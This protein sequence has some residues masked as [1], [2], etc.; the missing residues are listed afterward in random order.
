[1]LCK[2]FKKNSKCFVQCWFTTVT[3]FTTNLLPVN[4]QA[5][6]LIDQYHVYLKFVH[7]WSSSCSLVLY[8]RRIMTCPQPLP[9]PPLATLS[10]ILGISA[11]VHMCP[12]R[13]LYLPRGVPYLERFPKRGWP[14]SESR[15]PSNKAWSSLLTL[16]SDC[17]WHARQCRRW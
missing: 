17:W 2:A 8:I 10:P 13:V 3:I 15:W 9:F 11:P 6:C 1:M 7:N 5:V 16:K 12:D 4:L 14:Q